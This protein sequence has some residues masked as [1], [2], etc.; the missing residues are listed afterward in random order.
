MNKIEKFLRGL[1]RDEQEVFLLLMQQLEKDH[2]KVPG[3]KKLSG[4]KNLF[5]IRIG[6]YRLIFSAEKN[7]TEIIRITKRDENTYKGF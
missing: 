7:K 6:R 5:R 1:N 3:I 2:T 4:Y